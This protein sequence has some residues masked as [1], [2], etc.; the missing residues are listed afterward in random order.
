LPILS[1]AETAPL[2][3]RDVLAGLLLTRSVP[4]PELADD[5]SLTLPLTVLLSTLFFQDPHRLADRIESWGARLDPFIPH[6]GL[7]RWD[8]RQWIEHEG[9]EFLPGGG[10]WILDALA[11]D[12]R[13]VAAPTGVLP[14]IPPYA[15]PDGLIYFPTVRGLLLHGAQDLLKNIVQFTHPWP[16]TGEDELGPRA[17]LIRN[18]PE[19]AA[20]ARRTAKQIPLLDKLIAN[21]RHSGARAEFYRHL[22]RW[23][24][25]A[26]LTIRLGSPFLI[27]FDQT[28]PLIRTRA[29]YRRLSWF[30]KK[31]RLVRTFHE[32]PL[33]LRDASEVHAEFRIRNPEIRF[34]KT[35][36]VEVR[37]TKRLPVKEVFGHELRAGSRLIHIYS[38]KRPDETSPGEAGRTARRHLFVRFKVTL[39]SSV[40]LGYLF[41]AVGFL[42]ASSYVGVVFGLATLHDSEIKN[43]EAPVTVAALSVTLSLWLTAVQHPSPIVYRKLW[44]ARRAFYVSLAVS[45]VAT[46]AYAVRR[47]V[48][49][50]F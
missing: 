15:R 34:G 2:T 7:T 6:R 43:P 29:D 3:A 48:V 26:V 39:I 17:L 38:S 22:D 23:T 40:R 18:A 9:E 37:G 1:R 30:S 46:A 49:P 41:A 28:L 36:V 19:L 20:A 33:G 16:E 12:I 24:A 50:L 21:Q 31:W 14:L 45:L 42:L 11:A 35:K 5:I 10:T 8:L 25:Y 44:A 32:Y 27:K 47:K 13:Q 4:L